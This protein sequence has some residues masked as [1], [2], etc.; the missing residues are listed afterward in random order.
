MLQA[1]GILAAKKILE[2]KPDQQIVFTSTW[3]SVTFSDKLKAFSLDPAKFTLLQKPF[4]FSELLSVIRP[5]KF[6]I[7][8]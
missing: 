1:S 7:A 4:Q 2:E 8:S 6:S 3:D 5:P